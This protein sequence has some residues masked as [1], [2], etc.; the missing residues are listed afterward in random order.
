[1]SL[2]I[3]DDKVEKQHWEGSFMADIQQAK[4]SNISLAS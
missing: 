2:K 3:K 4:K 1:M